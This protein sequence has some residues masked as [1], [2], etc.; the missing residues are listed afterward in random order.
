MFFKPVENLSVCVVCLSVSANKGRCKGAFTDKVQTAPRDRVLSTHL[1][2][3]ASSRIWKHFCLQRFVRPG[4]KKPVW[5]YRFIMY[6]SILWKKCDPVTHFP[7]QQTAACQITVILV[8]SFICLLVHLRVRITSPPK[9]TCWRLLNI[10][11]ISSNFFLLGITVTLF[12]Q[13]WPQK[14]VKITKLSQAQ[15][16]T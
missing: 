8:H 5:S 1:A 3:T 2:C 12:L 6:E 9:Q 10:C 11:D 4:G 16:D 13:Q 14:H 15:A 7:P